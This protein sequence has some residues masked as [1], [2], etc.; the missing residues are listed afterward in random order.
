VTWSFEDTT[1]FWPYRSYWW[2]K[3]WSALKYRRREMPETCELR[4]FESI[5]NPAVR[6]LVARAFLQRAACQ[7]QP[8]IQQPKQMNNHDDGQHEAK[9]RTQAKR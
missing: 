1:R 3:L 4:T 5:W 7:Q 8:G 6:G 2:E 9:P